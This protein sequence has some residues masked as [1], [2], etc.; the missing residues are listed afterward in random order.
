MYK[1]PA[2]DYY[3]Q[4]KE[5]I[6]QKLKIDTKTYHKKKKT[7]LKSSKEKSI[8]NWFSTNKKRYKI[9]NFC[10]FLVLKKLVKRH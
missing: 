4:N 8:K 5:A 9:N 7:R 3:L 6:K 10:V 1:I 2:A